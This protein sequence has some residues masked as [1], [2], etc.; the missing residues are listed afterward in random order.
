MTTQRKQNA[1]VSKTRGWFPETRWSVVLAAQSDGKG[2]QDE[3]DARQAMEELCAMYWRPVFRFMRASG[4]SVEDAKDLTQDFFAKL[5]DLDSFK[6]V[7][8]EKGK[9]R[10]F[11]LIS[12]KRFL[13]S[14]LHKERALKR[15]RGMKPLSLDVSED[16]EALAAVQMADTVTPEVQF[17]RQWVMTL[18][19]KVLSDLEQ[20]HIASERAEFFQAT[21]EF[22]TCSAEQTP[23][24]QLADQLQLTEGA[25][26][27]AVY[28]MRRRY[29]DLLQ[30]EIAN[31][32]D[33]SSSVEEE[34]HYLMS[35]FGDAKAPFM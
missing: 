19:E 22:L 20:E 30:A 14:D 15:G 28:R 34:I 4:R 25:V 26:R 29:R 21:K 12:A 13:I 9:L 24:C 33:S 23:Y 11:L 5:I 27:V 3:A 2:E 18:L 7:A 1:E 16:D 8:Q 17:D 32:V 35:V 31:T 10:S 6:S